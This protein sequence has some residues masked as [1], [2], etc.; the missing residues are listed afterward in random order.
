[1]KFSPT[2]L[3]GCWKVQPIVFADERGTFFK[4]FQAEQFSAAGLAFEW[5]EE[6]YSASRKNVIRGMH[7]QLPPYDHDKLVY[8][9]RGRA[10]DVVLDLRRSSETY[11]HHLAI[12]LDSVEGHGLLIPRGLA[13]GFLSLTD[14]VLMAY[15]TSS[16]HAPDHDKG[17]RW[18]SFGFDWGVEGPIVS[19]RDCGHQAFCDFNS[20]F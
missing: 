1:M 13:H 20:P 15:K 18:D 8:C 19:K 14:D 9:L 16:A 3:A 5:R 11:G 12:H 17:I 4:T 2:P 10:L 7:F 6:F